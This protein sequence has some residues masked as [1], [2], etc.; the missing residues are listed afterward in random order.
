M[1]IIE[2]YNN[3]QQKPTLFFKQLIAIRKYYTNSSLAY[4]VCIK[5]IRN[6]KFS[7]VF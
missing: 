5:D 7:A 1:C 2:K 4:V 3:I 6:C